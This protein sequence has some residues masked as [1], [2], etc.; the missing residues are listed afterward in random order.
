MN[1][2]RLWRMRLAEY[3]VGLRPPSSDALPSN[4]RYQY[5]LHEAGHAVVYSV[6]GSVVTKVWSARTIHPGKLGGQCRFLPP[7]DAFMGAVGT[8]A[9]GVAEYLAGFTVRPQYYAKEHGQAVS[10]IG[11]DRFRKA[12]LEAGRLLVEQFD[13]V[14]AIT[15]ALVERGELSGD[16]VR[17]IIRRCQTG[18]PMVNVENRARVAA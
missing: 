2:R 18:A 11:T 1:P 15:R 5:A 9:G 6:L 12:E 10:L 14:Q 7:A 13:A 4:T 16:E 17:R 3:D 8:V